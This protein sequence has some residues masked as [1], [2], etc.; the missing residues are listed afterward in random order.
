MAHWAELDENN[1]V[2]R[3]VVGSNNDPDEGYQWI[4]DNLGGIWVKTSYNT[5]FGTHV[6]GGTPLRKNYAGIGSIY[7]P[8]RDAFYSQSPF[9]SWILNEDTCAWEAPIPMPVVD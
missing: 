2:I 5:R 4:I 3:V 6:T 8:E 1:V 9:S 7:D